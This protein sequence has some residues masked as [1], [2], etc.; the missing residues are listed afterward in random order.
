VALNSGKTRPLIHIFMALIS[1]IWPI[2]LIV[3]V[4]KIAG[5]VKEHEPEGLELN[6]CQFPSI[7]TTRVN[8]TFQGQFDQTAWLT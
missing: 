3:C 2:Q 4:K 7:S 8:L 5:N 1:L 6:P